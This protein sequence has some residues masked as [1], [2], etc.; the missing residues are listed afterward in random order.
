M[1]IFD[2][3]VSLAFA[4]RGQL[5][6]GEVPGYV[7]AQVVGG[8]KA[9]P[10]AVPTLVPLYITGAYWF[11]AST[12]FANPAVTIARGFS[13]TVAGIAPGAYPGVYRSAADCGGHWDFLR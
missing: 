3:A 8:I 13:D 1:P 10:N 12:S 2:T 9:R 5:P 4:L 6:W 11:T 7:G